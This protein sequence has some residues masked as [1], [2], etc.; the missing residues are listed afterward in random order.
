METNTI[1]NITLDDLER[2]IPRNKSILESVEKSQNNGP[3]EWRRPSNPLELPQDLASSKDRGF[4]SSP[5]KKPY[6]ETKVYE[7]KS[8]SS[9]FRPPEGTY[10][11]V[12]SVLPHPS[13]APEKRSYSPLASHS[14]RIYHEQ[15]SPIGQRLSTPE[16]NHQRVKPN[17]AS[18]IYEGNY[19]PNTPSQTFQ[20]SPEL[21]SLRNRPSRV[22]NNQ[23]PTSLNY[24]Q[25]HMKTNTSHASPSKGLTSPS[26][27]NS[28]GMATRSPRSPSFLAINGLTPKYQAETSEVPYRLNAS[29]KPRNDQL[30]TA[31]Q[32]KYIVGGLGSTIS[33]SPD[34]LRQVSQV[35]D[36]TFNRSFVTP[37]KNRTNKPEPIQL[38]NV[39]KSP[40]QGS[41]IPS[42][43]R[44][45]ASR[46]NSPFA[47]HNRQNNKFSGGLI[48]N[49]IH[50]ST[51][52]M[53]TIKSIDGSRRTTP[54]QPVASYLEMSPEKYVVSPDRY[55][56]EPNNLVDMESGHRSPSRFEIPTSQNQKDQTGQFIR[57]APYS[58]APLNPGAR[59]MT[60]VT[61][62]HS[63]YEEPMEE[64]VVRERTT[65]LVTTNQNGYQEYGEKPYL[66]YQNSVANSAFN[67]PSTVYHENTPMSL[68]YITNKTRDKPTYSPKQ[69]VFDEN[70]T[71]MFSTP[72]KGGRQVIH[73]SRIQKGDPVEVSRTTL[74]IGTPVAS[75]SVVDD[76]NPKVF[77]TRNEIIEHDVELLQRSGYVQSSPSS[78]RRNY[79]PRLSN[80]SIPQGNHPISSRSYLTQANDQPSPRILSARELTISSPPIKDRLTTS[81]IGENPYIR[82]SNQKI[83]PHS[84]G[85][86]HGVS[87]EMISILNRIFERYDCNNSQFIERSEVP[88]LMIDTYR[89]IGYNFSPNDDDI[90]SYMKN[91]DL[92]EDGLISKDEFIFVCSESLKQRGLIL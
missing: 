91:M 53:A 14:P 25:S 2:S 67:R 66:D 26:Y 46:E 71:A 20:R 23:T 92:S 50:K 32:N 7:G 9:V 86:I 41:F 63:P 21:S 6:I 3:R 4:T 52:I 17:Q 33:F 65:P 89:A 68:S 69:H 5:D 38:T 29:N 83:R 56:K 81:Q 47:T 16:I 77:K 35:T 75:Y 28:G 18:R 61:S 45:N 88:Q 82:N 54:L 15:K 34:K 48:Q 78:N 37:T 11:T 60:V 74:G 90:D 64:K 76:S 42:S 24:S 8:S 30:N 1:H 58:Q 12:Q 44:K 40:I 72:V 70:V 19:S 73:P 59:T 39:K 43:L 13:I 85:N 80:I 31:S 27:L 62:G 36:T 87:S 51:E 79:Q 84:Q 10:Q 22:I 49:E 55:W 57:S